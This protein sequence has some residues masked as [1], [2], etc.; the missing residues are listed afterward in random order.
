[1]PA[2]LGEQPEN[3]ASS[4]KNAEAD[5]H[6]AQPNTDG[7]VAV[8]VEGLSWPEKQDGEEIRTRDEGDNESEKKDPRLF[9]Y[10]SGK[11]GVFGPICLPPDEAG[12]EC[13]SYKERREDVCRLPWVLIISG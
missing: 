12:Q 1:M 7:V 11:H 2:E 8:G 10:P 13:S 4:A 5:R 6:P 3:D 9:L